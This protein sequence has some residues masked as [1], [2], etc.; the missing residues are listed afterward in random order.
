[1][2][3]LLLTASTALILAASAALLAASTA[4]YPG[5]LGGFP[6]GLGGATAHGNRP[7]PQ[8]GGRIIPESLEGGNTRRLKMGPCTW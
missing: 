8:A 4:P 7:F 6:D 1:M 3:A 5:G 2:A